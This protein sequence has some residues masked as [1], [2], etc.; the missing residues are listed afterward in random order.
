[1][2]LGLSCRPR[3]NRL[4]RF[5]RRNRRTIPWRKRSAGRRRV[6]AGPKRKK[7]DRG[8]FEDEDEW[9]GEHAA[10]RSESRE[11]Y[12]EVEV[13][14]VEFEEVEFGETTEYRQR[15]DEG[16]EDRD[17]S[18]RRRRRGGRGRG[19]GRRERHPET[20]SRGGGDQPREEGGEFAEE[21]QSRAG[22]EGESFRDE[23][24]TERDE[25]GGQRGSRR[26]GRRG[27]GGSR[28]GAGR[29]R[30]ETRKT[31]RSHQPTRR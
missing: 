5:C 29:R 15:S 19:N 3:V 7:K 25:Q 10:E 8:S 24:E 23:T 22:G 28:E 14:D 4:R 11:E 9:Q 12:R 18:Q 17:R 26:R 21:I 27:R 16:S 30:D 2:N 6:C 31:C 20:E 13:R 1:M